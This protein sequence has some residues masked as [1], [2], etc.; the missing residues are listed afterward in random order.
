M[1]RSFNL[2]SLHLPKK[3]VLSLEKA[4]RDVHLGRAPRAHTVRRQSERAHPRRRMLLSP[5]AV[6]WLSGRRRAAGAA[7]VALILG[8]VMF[9]PDPRGAAIALAARWS[10]PLRSHQPAA[11]P[12]PAPPPAQPRSLLDELLDQYHAWARPSVATTLGFIF[13]VAA[14]F[15]TTS[16]LCFC[17]Q[18]CRGRQKFVVMDTRPLV[19]A[20]RGSPR[21]PDQ[22]VVHVAQ[23][24]CS[25]TEG[26]DP[27]AAAT[28][29]PSQPRSLITRLLIGS[30]QRS[31]EH[32]DS[33][34]DGGPV[35]E[36]VFLPLHRMSAPSPQ[37]AAAAPAA[38]EC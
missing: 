34:S 9:S 12:P 6:V 10:A 38:F 1:H 14:F 33:G 15:V 27:S 32:P 25:T 18:A 26:T 3:A 28:D 17:L 29:A 24:A 30:P 16:A 22:H 5:P 13:M 21:E 37:T 7:V 35:S 19:P 11:P 36:R 23:Q 4:A 2:C 20:T 8:A 31:D